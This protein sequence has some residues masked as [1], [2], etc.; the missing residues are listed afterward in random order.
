MMPDP[1]KRFCYVPPGSRTPKRYECQPDMVERDVLALAIVG[2]LR[3]G[4]RARRRTT[5]RRWAC[6]T[7]CISRSGQRV[8]APV[9][10]NTRR[11]G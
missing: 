3:G 9:W 2:A 10:M 4:D 7:T 11:P 5:S 6:F 1:G 8:C